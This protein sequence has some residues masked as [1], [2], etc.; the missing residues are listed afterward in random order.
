VIIAHLIASLALSANPSPDVWQWS[1]VLAADIEPQSH[2][3][4]AAGL[5]KG[6]F[7]LQYNTDTLDV[8]YG[9]DF[10][11]GRWWVTARGEGLVAGLMPFPWAAGGPAP[12]QA[13]YA[14]YVGGSAG[15][16]KY[17]PQ[18]LWA[19]VQA[20]TR[21][22]I[23]GAVDGGLAPVPDVRP[24]FAVGA[25]LGWYSDWLNIRGKSGVDV[26]DVA[27]APFAE[28]QARLTLP[29]WW[30]PLLEFRG[31]L[32]INQ[33]YVT[34]TRLGGVSPYAVP[35]AGAGWAEWWVQN[36]A[37]VHAGPQISWQS[38]K[39]ALFA[40]AAHFDGDNALGLGASLHQ[41]FGLWYAD[42]VAGWAPKIERQA[43]VGRV[44]VWLA[45]GRDWGSL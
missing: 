14:S 22:Y 44:S 18:G 45:V 42:V 25:E 4:L 35:L 32:G 16:I 29:G 41:S 38:G 37:A 7:A 33:D 43:G 30:A 17:L 6:A 12:E 11:G 31:G 2:G 8:T 26:S 24:S 3:V 27:T 39:A 15:V 20:S 28:V 23:F 19:G 5:R 10:D 1:A 9:P 36:Y 13:V 34:R 21:T 40:D